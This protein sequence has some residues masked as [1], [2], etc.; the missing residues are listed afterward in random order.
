MTDSGARRHLEEWRCGATGKFL[1]LDDGTLYAWKTDPTGYPH[2]AQGMEAFRRPALIEGDIGRDGAMEVLAVRPD[3]SL[4][5]IKAR[6]AQAALGLG[7]R[8]PAT[9]AEPDPGERTWDFG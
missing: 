5:G 4:D 7:L 1:V 8:P 2:H 9:W 3:A 6:A